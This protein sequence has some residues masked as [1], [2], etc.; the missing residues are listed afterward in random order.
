MASTPIS[1]IKGI[2]V[3]E[4]Q[5]GGRTLHVKTDNNRYKSVSN[6][7]FE[8]KAFVKFEDKEHTKFNGYKPRQADNL[9]KYKIKQI[10]KIDILYS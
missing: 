9:R 10:P 7:Y 2:S 4:D 8:I 3:R 6:F 1:P 5:A